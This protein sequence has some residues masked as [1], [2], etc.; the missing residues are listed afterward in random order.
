MGIRD[1]SMTRLGHDLV[2]GV[3]I[4]RVDSLDPEIIAHHTHEMLPRRTIVSDKYGH[5]RWVSLEGHATLS[6]GTS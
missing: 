6:L 5:K 2:H 4:N 1:R 3:R